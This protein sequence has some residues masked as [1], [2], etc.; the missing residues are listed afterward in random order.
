VRWRS[1]DHLMVGENTGAPPA[2]GARERLEDR[3]AAL[4]ER[5]AA[6]EQAAVRGFG[7]HSDQD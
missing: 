3:I 5:V 6:L 1:T 7:T 2:E 4:E